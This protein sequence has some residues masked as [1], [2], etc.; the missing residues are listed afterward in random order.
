MKR[1][2]WL[3]FVTT[4]IVCF[5]HGI[6]SCLT[7]TYAQ[8]LPRTVIWPSA[9]TVLDPSSRTVSFLFTPPEAF[10]DRWSKA[11][12]ALFN[13]TLT[14]PCSIVQHHPE[15]VFLPQVWIDFVTELEF[16]VRRVSDQ[17]PV[18]RTA[19]FNLCDLFGSPNLSRDLV[20]GCQ[21]WSRLEAWK[22]LRIFYDIQSPVGVPDA[23]TAHQRQCV[24]QL[25][26]NRTWTV[27]VTRMMKR[28]MA[29][30]SPWTRSNATLPIFVYSRRI[31]NVS[32]DGHMTFQA[33]F[34]LTYWMDS[35]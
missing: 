18:D 29:D 35:K 33:V 34:N 9:P 1:C 3:L 12:F 13:A 15:V 23:W 32:R 21:D 7:T 11:D 14:L 28:W 8:S 10:L 30:R 16:G 6:E 27:P 4:L 2:L 20:P 31:Q 5:D 19:D 17:T 25:D 22:R 26:G 24:G